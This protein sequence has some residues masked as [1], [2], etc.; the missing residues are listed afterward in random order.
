MKTF[1][2]VEDYIIELYEGSYRFNANSQDIDY[3]L[4]SYDIRIVQS[5]HNQVTFQSV[6]LTDKQAEL[7]VKLVE[8]Y[9]RQ[10]KRAGI[11]NFAMLESSTRKFKLGIR[12]VN[13]DY[14]IHIKDDLIHATFPY[15]LRLIS[16]IRKRSEKSGGVRAIWSRTDKVWKF[17]FTEPNV[18]FTISFGQDYD[19]DID[20]KLL[21]IAGKLAKQDWE[22]YNIKLVEHDGK[23]TIQN[24]PVSLSEYVDKHAGT[25]LLSLVDYSGIC[26]YQ[27]D[28]NIANQ[29]KQ[30]HTE[31]V[32]ACL[33]GKHIWLDP[34]KHSFNDIIKYAELTDRFPVTVYDTLGNFGPF[35]NQNIE[36]TD[37]NFKYLY[38]RFL[39]LSE[40]V[41]PIYHH[42]TVL[43]DNWPYKN[44]D[45][46]TAR[47]KIYSSASKD[48]FI[49]DIPLL[50]CSQNFNYGSLRIQM[51][52][53]SEKIVYHCVKL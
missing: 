45:P 35:L 11:D 17:G 25:D 30:A 5:I 31:T 1:N 34:K 52:A 32:S 28:N 33:L 46:K 18:K 12:K 2:Y 26:A 41:G 40:R 22:H 36:K 13:R 29:I 7:C 53:K 10:F 43:P 21:E 15:N 50:V 16:E 23:Y 27:V 47:I 20:P 37:S 38:S 8:K 6:A 44:A 48:M 39:N 51:L 14:K 19:F 4:A 49:D 42:D 3:R 24:C 9:T